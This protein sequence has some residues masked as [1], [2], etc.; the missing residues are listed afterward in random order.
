MNPAGEIITT[1]AGYKNEISI[2]ILITAYKALE[3]SDALD[4]TVDWRK[5]AA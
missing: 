3:T 5:P 2:I 1:I 4:K